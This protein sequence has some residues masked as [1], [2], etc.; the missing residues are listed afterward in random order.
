MKLIGLSG[1]IAT[2]KTTVATMFKELGCYIID[3]DQLAHEALKIDNI[4]EEILSRFG[5][6]LSSNG[7]IDRKKLGNIVL[8]NKGK[9]AVLENIIHPTVEVIR[10]RKLEAIKKKHPDAI[11]IYET[12]LL[13]EKSLEHIFCCTVVVYT[14]R[15]T[16]IKRLMKRNGFSEEEALQRILLQM[17]IEEKIRRADFVI[18]NSNSLEHTR[19]QVEKTLKEIKRVPL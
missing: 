1:S 16:Q 14:N 8:K 12:P 18:D 11:V 4:R 5:D 2:G 17:P 6:V 10:N 7:N 13:F 9:L 19:K 3:A 15:H